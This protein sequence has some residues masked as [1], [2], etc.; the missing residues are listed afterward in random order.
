MARKKFCELNLTHAFMFAAAMTDPVVFRVTLEVLLGKTVKK[1]NVNVEHS[2]LFSSD[3]IN[4]CGEKTKRRRMRHLVFS[5]I[6]SKP[7]AKQMI[8]TKCVFAS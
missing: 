5:A 7:S 6:M 2:L 8:S 1:V 3:S 4:I